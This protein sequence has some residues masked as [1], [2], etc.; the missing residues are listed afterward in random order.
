MDNFKVQF[1]EVKTTTTVDGKDKVT[2]SETSPYTLE[3]GTK[4]EGNIDNNGKQNKVTY[5][6]KDVSFHKEIYRPG[7]VEFVVQITLFTP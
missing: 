3:H 6:L 5:L 7:E 4:K 2:K 1:Y